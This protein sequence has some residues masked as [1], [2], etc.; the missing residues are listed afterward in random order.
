M[1]PELQ[2]RIEHLCAQLSRWPNIKAV[3][4]AGGGG[5]DLQELAELLQ[6]DGEIGDARVRQLLNEIGDAAAK[7]G[8]PGMTSRPR[9]PIPSLPSA[10]AALPPGMYPPPI[11][12]WTCPLGRCSRVVLP[13]EAVSPGTSDGVPHCATGTK[14]MAEYRPDPQLP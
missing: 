12:G 13:G 6:A 8:L 7:G 5:A 10:M 3:I 11:A 1:D 2:R 9:G 4:V 14:P